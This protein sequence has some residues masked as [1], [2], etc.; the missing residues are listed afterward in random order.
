[1][2]QFDSLEGMDIRVRTVSVHYAM[3]G[4]FPKIHSIQMRFQ[5]VAKLD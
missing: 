4:A 5:A 3:F 2:E 1:M